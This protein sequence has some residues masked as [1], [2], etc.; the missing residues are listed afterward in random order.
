[1]YACL[2]SPTLSRRPI[3][4]RRLV[5][6]SFVS[7]TFLSGVPLLPSRSFVSCFGPFFSPFVSSKE[8]RL[9]ILS[10]FYGPVHPHDPRRRDSNSGGVFFDFAL[11]PLPALV[12]AVRFLTRLAGLSLWVIFEGGI[13]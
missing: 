6:F 2:T 12:E 9:G 8:D 7:Q 1:V 3:L 5:F 11:A 13:D 10:Y 4:I